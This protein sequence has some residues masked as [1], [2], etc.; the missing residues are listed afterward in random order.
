MAA[1]KEE[2]EECGVLWRQNVRE[3]VD[4]SSSG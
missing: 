2:G 3:D 4:E 1:Q